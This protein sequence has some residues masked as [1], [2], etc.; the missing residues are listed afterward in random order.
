MNT[1]RRSLAASALG[2]GKLF[3][4]TAT[5]A[6][7]NSAIGQP[8]LR[9]HRATYQRVFRLAKDLIDVLDAKIYRRRFASTLF[10]RA[11]K[12]VRLSAPAAARH[13]GTSR[14]PRILTNRA[15]HHYIPQSIT[16]MNAPILP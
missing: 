4:R 13:S 5:H 7:D 9:A 16:W 11:R 10:R 3:P 1:F 6:I 8:E 15:G 12:N 2:V 14:A